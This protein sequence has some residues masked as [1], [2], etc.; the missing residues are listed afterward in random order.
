VLKKNYF[1]IVALGFKTLIFVLLFGSIILQPTLKSI[2]LMDPQSFSWLDHDS[3]SENN[4]NDNKEF[5]D[6][7]EKKVELRL[8][9]IDFSSNSFIY[10]VFNYRLYFLKYNV[11]IDIHDPPPEAV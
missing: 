9:V 7:K 6:S 11:T 4:E 10:K 5:E 2:S 3:E 1:N 8:T